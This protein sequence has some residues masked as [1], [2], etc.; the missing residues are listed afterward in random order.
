GAGGREGGQGGVQG[1]S[2]G[3][4]LCDVEIDLVGTRGAVGLGDGPAQGAVVAVIGVDDRE[5]AEQL[6]GFEGFHAGR[7]ARAG[8]GERL[9]VFPAGPALKEHETAPL[10]GQKPKMPSWIGDGLHAAVARVVPAMRFFFRSL[11][12]KEKKIPGAGPWRCGGPG[13]PCRVSSSARGRGE[14]GG[15]RWTRGRALDSPA[16]SRG[17]LPRPPA[18]ATTSTPT[19]PGSPGPRPAR[20]PR[21]PRR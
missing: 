11:S 14:F 16:P 2:F 7:E 3:S 5:G 10:T 17:P 8:C 21:R 13:N 20:G 19:P 9:A 15:P 6:A 1:D 12:L 4:V 18:P